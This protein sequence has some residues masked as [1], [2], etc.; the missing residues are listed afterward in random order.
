MI[1]DVKC[2]SSGEAHRTH[3]AN[4]ETLTPKDEVKFVVSGR[5]D[6]DW[7]AERVS[8]HCLGERGLAVLVSPVAGVLEPRDLARWVLDSRLPLRLQLQL[9][10]LL[11]PEC[12]R[13][14]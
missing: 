1:M 6:F 13:G 2:P 9:H 4:I 5:T 7:A 10:R 3:W 12:D 11:W 14:V 8:E